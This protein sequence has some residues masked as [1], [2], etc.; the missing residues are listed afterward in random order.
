MITRDDVPTLS[1]FHAR[2]GLELTLLSDGDGEIIRAFGVASRAYPAGS[3]YHG[4]AHPIVLA[5]DARGVVRLRF[6]SENPYRRPNVDAVLG[7]L[8]RHGRFRERGSGNR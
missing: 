8:G 6:S 2:R 3:A 5:T 4:I 7:A 1:R